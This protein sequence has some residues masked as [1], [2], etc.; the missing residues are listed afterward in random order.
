MCIMPLFGVWV[1]P[2]SAASRVAESINCVSGYA[3]A[4]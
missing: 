4:P 2:L 1:L 3:G